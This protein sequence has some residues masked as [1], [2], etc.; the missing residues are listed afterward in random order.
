[1]TLKKIEPF[2]HESSH[3]TTSSIQTGQTLISHFNVF[4]GIFWHYNPSQIY[5]AGAPNWIINFLPFDAP[6]PSIDSPPSQKWPSN[7]APL[8]LNGCTVKLHRHSFSNVF[9]I[10]FSRPGEQ[11]LNLQTALNYLTGRLQV[12]SEL[13]DQQDFPAGKVSPEVEFHD[14]TS[15]AARRQ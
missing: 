11:R 12:T 8:V 14:E 1:M 7:A 2:Y 4:F 15:G 6:L 3:F 5:G 10:S 13:W 9:G